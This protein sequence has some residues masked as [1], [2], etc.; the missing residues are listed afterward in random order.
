MKYKIHENGWTALLEDFDFNTATQ[1]NILEIARLIAKHTCV[2]VR[3]QHLTVADQV[4]I[5]KM[6]KN[7]NPL[8]KPEDEFF[9]DCVADITQDPT[10]I[11]CRVSGELNE[12][13]KP[14]IAGHV[15]EMQWHCNHPYKE[16]RSPIVWLYGVKGTKGS[17]TSWNN[18]ILSYNDL[19]SDTKH[20]L[21]DLKCIYYGGMQHTTEYKDS[22]T[23]GKSKFV[24][25][26]FTP[27]I[28][29]TNNAGKTGLYFSLLQL[30]KFEGM[31]REE[32]LEIAKPLFEHTIQE[33]YC[34]HHDWEDGDIVL[35]EQWLGIHKRWRFEQ[36]Y[37][38]VLH[39]MVF[40]F[41]D[42]DYLNEN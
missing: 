40:D 18:N 16:D 39:R 41:P 7:P 1:E 10:G 11:V 22:D 28:I 30:E 5:A 24:I 31:S 4:R 21:H 32:S 38:R 15:D 35:S 25:E 9:M 3:G 29:H 8:F 23:F 12:H 17:R 2:V 34:Y 19:D 26:N 33:K 42:Q 13:G 37:T 6:F 27:N 20:K 14:G 36:I